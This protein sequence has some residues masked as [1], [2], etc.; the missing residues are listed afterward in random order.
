[1][2]VLQQSRKDQGVIVT[3]F[4]TIAMSADFALL[5]GAAWQLIDPSAGLSTI[6]GATSLRLCMSG[7][8]AAAIAFLILMVRLGGADNAN[9]THRLWY[10]RFR[11]RILS[12]NVGHFYARGVRRALARLDR[13]MGDAGKQDDGMLPR[14]FGLLRHRAPLWTTRSFDRCLLLALLYPLIVIL[15][16]WLC[17][18]T[19]GAGHLGPAEQ[20]LGL[21]EASFAARLTSTAP[22]VIFFLA[23][24]LNLRSGS[25]KT[26]IVTTIFG[27]VA[28]LIMNSGFGATSGIGGFAF[29]LTL[30]IIG[31]ASIGQIY[32]RDQ[33]IGRRLGLTYPILFFGALFILTKSPEL[34]TVRADYY[35][36]SLLY[37]LGLLTL[38]NAPFDWIALGLTRA[39]LRAGLERRGL[40]PLGLAL[41]DAIVSLAIMALLALAILWAT[42]YF[43]ASAIA[44]GA[45]EVVIDPLQ[46]LNALAKPA[47]RS[48]PEYWWL[49]AMLFSTQIPSLLNLIFGM[50]CA[51]RGL[52]RVN[53]WM[54]ANLPEKG[55]IDLWPRMG[56]AALWSTQLGIA[57]TL[58]CLGLW[59][60]FASLLW[61][62]DGM[63]GAS[64]LELLRHASISHLL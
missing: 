45:K 55:G 60:L 21:K 28:I 23:M 12:G 47:E 53:H 56:V 51:L 19:P 9:H 48:E 31:T 54:A 30:I 1:M 4:V 36:F 40:W 16:T 18:G 41:A 38:V 63:F 61:A 20:A 39:F 50:F 3:T 15:A 8:I 5:S 17:Y 64:L 33:L 58:G 11:A 37:F 46:Y 13:F 32:I 42:E 52:P 44:G 2:G 35:V 43:N 57:V 29:S 6:I 26:L 62:V 59:W 14:A 7:V 27:P 34:F 25:W 24:T 49:Y 10:L 22:I